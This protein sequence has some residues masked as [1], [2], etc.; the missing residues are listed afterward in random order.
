[1]TLVRLKFAVPDTTGQ[2]PSEG[3]LRWTPT[4]RRTAGDTVVMPAGF[5]ATL[6][7]GEAVI[8]VDP[9]GA[10]WVW[11]VDENVPTSYGTSRYVAVP[12][13][14]TEVNYTTL[15][16]VDPATLEPSE[17]PDPAWYAYVDTLEGQAATASAS[18]VAAKTAAEAAQASAT[19]SQAGAAASAVTAT[20]KAAEASTS[21][22]NAAASAATALGHKNDA[23]ASAGAAANSATA[24][25]NSAV[26]AGN[27]ATA[28][29]NS[30]THATSMADL[31]QSSASDTIAAANGF[32]IGTVT[33]GNPG[34]PATATITGTAPDKKLNLGLPKGETGPANSLTVL[35]TTTG[36][37]TPGA[38]GPQGLKGDKGDPGGFTTGTDLAAND[39]NNITVPGLYRQANAA[40]VTLALNYP[41]AS[42]A[43]TGILTV[44]EQSAGGNGGTLQVYD[45]VWGNSS[46]RLSFHRTKTNGVWQAWRSFSDVRV[47]ET[48]GRVFY[49]WDS[50]NLREQLV[51][52][53]TG[54]RNII[55][56]SVS[57]VGTL[58]IRRNG[59]MV[60]INA[61]GLNS[62]AGA[63]Y[64]IIFASGQLPGFQPSITARGLATTAA[65]AARILDITGG[66]EM[67]LFG[68]EAAPYSFSITYP[69]ND[70]WPT[71][72]PGTASGTIP[73][74]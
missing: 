25:N 13:L 9:T 10:D 65:G 42:N 28:A 11:R 24:A 70:N 45:I 71:T 68:P 5:V 34:D 56:Q 40:N 49:M 38:T 63:S 57:Q 54:W 16:Q 64:V 17:D 51:Y 50:L 62:T 6:T 55:L 61:V 60:T 72:L 21:A 26:S 23:A 41:I 53:D 39:L 8:D 4:K 47:S 48:A 18:A 19:G 29:A 33:T 2:K 32:S 3:A 52:G 27:S 31:A 36:P 1:M 35:E 74:L 58:H 73:N 7:N 22:T 15:V 66:A 67:R 59:Q 30:D 14:G 12:D 37:E 69:T 44:T 43:G 20:T 46:G